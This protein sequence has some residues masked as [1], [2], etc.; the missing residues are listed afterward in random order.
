MTE[1]SAV[2]RRFQFS[3]R[4]L[5]IVTGLLALLLVPVA[6]L[7]RQRELMHRAREEALRSLVLEQR[8]RADLKK[9]K[10]AEV[11]PLDRDGLAGAGVVR[12]TSLA[13][14][15]ASAQIERLQRENAELRKTVEH[16]RREVERLEAR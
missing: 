7:A 8:Y 13:S 11:A 5:L 16:L 3:L 14:P 12:Q 2:R 4:S 9:R 6:R 15:D 1:G 10:A